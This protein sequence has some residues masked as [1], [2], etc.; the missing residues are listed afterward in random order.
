MIQKPWQEQLRFAVRDPVLLHEYLDLV[1]DVPSQKQAFPL[2]VTHSFINRMEA[3]NPSDPL[4][5]Q[6]QIRSQ[7]SDPSLR[8]VEF[9]SDPTGERSALQQKGL[10]QK[11]QGRA[12]L[13]LTSTCAIHCRYCFRREFPYDEL[14]QSQSELQSSLNWLDEQKDISEVILSGG[15]PLSLGTERLRGSIER[16]MKMKHIDTIRIHTRI[17]SVLPARIDLELMQLIAQIQT[18]KSLVIVTH[19]NHPAEIQY[20]C[21]DALLRLVESGATLLNQS[22]LLRDIN[23]QVAT[24]VALS[25][26]L[27]RF[28][29]LPYY[30]HQLDRVSY[31]EHFEVDKDKGLAII[32]SM[33]AELPGYLVPKYV[34]ED[35]GAK[36]KTALA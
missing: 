26:R 19:I 28:G 12:L 5:A 16:L 17:P 15:D 18:K 23:D 31:T 20:D 14:P 3:G 32:E 33:R 22:V 11:Y 1:M 35:A 8:Q 30:L 27:F 13:L 6:V 21:E 34:R 29:V 36:N 25:K 9:G 4:L 10:M 24:Q 7:E 2:T